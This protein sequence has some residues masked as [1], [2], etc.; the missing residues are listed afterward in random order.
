MSACCAPR[1]TPAS[2]VGGPAHLPFTVPER[3][4]AE[5]IRTMARIP[6]GVFEMGSRDGDGFPEDGEGPVRE[7]TLRPYYIDTTCVKN[8]AFARF[9]KE[10]GY[11]TDAERI[12]WSFVFAPLVAP[13]DHAKVLNASVPQAPWWVGV[14][15][16]NWRAPD[17]PASTIGSRGNHPAVQVSWQDATAYAAWAGKR[18][19]TEAEWECAA[20]GG[21]EGARYPWGD[22]L[23]P[24]GR[25]QCN[26]WRGVFPTH[27]SAADGYISTAPVNAFRPNRYGL[28]N[29]SGNVWEWCA[30]R[31]SATW[32]V[33]GR[34]ETRN[35]PQGPP[36][37]ESRVLRGGSYLCHDSYCNRYRV[38]GRTGNTPHTSTGH[39]G[40]RCATDDPSRDAAGSAWLAGP[41]RLVDT[42]TRSGSKSPTYV[43]RR[44]PAERR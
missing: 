24:R 22:E 8:A 28:Y 4:P 31:W 17:G 1:N 7:V 29:C 13:A 11:V 39:M 32:H 10:T 42:P 23:A 27:N 37:G 26:I 5:V 30:D 14:H 9:V 18:L 41:G 3:A 20:R 2:S 36:T 35:N 15:G 16:A 33:A 40:F 25:R 44:T 38:A 19:P 6:G 21:L 43:S 34:P 12:G